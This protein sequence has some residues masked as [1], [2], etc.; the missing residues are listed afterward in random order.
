M[1]FRSKRCCK[2][3][4]ETHTIEKTV[5]FTAAKD[6]TI[7]ILRLKKPLEAALASLRKN[8]GYEKRAEALRCIAGYDGIPEKEVCYL[9]GASASSVQT[10][11][12]AGLV[13]CAEQQ[14]FRRVVSQSAEQ[15]PPILL[16]E[17]QQRAYDGIQALEPPAAALLPGVTG[18]GKT[19]VYIR[20]VQAALESG[21]SAIV[22]TPEISLTPQ[23]LRRFCGYFPDQVADRK[24]VV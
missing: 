20:L 7:R 6:Q 10:L 22:L 15:A 2:E 11:I 5:R 9:T 8:N 1:L 19:E 21:R 17:E 4:L 18:S 3:L 14:T 16:E 23:L 13:D 24:S 12:R